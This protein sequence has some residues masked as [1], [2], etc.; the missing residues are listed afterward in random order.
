M[1]EPQPAPVVPLSLVRPGR[2]DPHLWRGVDRLVD[3]APTATDLRS[4]RIEPLAARRLRA[5]G[6]VVPEELA[7][8]ERRAAVATLAGPVLLERVRAACDGPLLLFKGPEAAARYPDPALRQFKDLD[9]LAPDAEAAQRSLVAAGFRP[10]GDP[11]LYLGI[12]HL[13]P[14]ALRGL[15]L[16]VEIHSRPKWPGSLESPS[17]DELFAAAV[18]SATG[19]SGVLAPA[20]AH[21]A[22]L[23][24]GHSW[25]HEPL[26]RLRDLVDIAAMLQGVDQFELRRLAR[27]WS[28]ERLWETTVASVDA[29]LYGGRPP[30]ALRFWA[31]NL[32]KVRE[33]TVL[34]NHLERVLSNFWIL[35]G[36]DALA[37]LLSIL[38][39]EVRPG[40]DETWPAK[41]SRSGRAA[42]NALRRRSE[43]EATLERRPP[44]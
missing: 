5:R 7:L 23:L 15:P 32:L 36:P 6:R 18:P 24:A 31:R 3:R 34:E 4:H 29:V 9:L 13:R 44:P 42:R 30:L 21:H 20:P 16:A 22:L 27:A 26:R 35:P 17:T 43:H 19:V 8:E 12:H 39:G 2:L 38:A 1:P 10:I 25:A 14:L 11:S 40:R 33:R 41:L 37:E 28:V